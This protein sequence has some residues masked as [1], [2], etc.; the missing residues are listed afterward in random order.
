M[1]SQRASGRKLNRMKKFLFILLAVVAL[2]ENSFAQTPYGGTT[3]R[4]HNVSSGTIWLNTVYDWP[5]TTCGTPSRHLNLIEDQNVAPGAT[6]TFTMYGVSST[7]NYVTYGSCLITGIYIA[8]QQGAVSQPSQMVA[9]ITVSG[10]GESCDIY[11]TTATTS[12]N[13][14]PTSFTNFTYCAKNQTDYPE[15]ATIRFNGAIVKTD[16]V[17]AGQQTCYTT[18]SIQVLPTPDAFIVSIT[19]NPMI[20][21]NGDDNFNQDTNTGTLYFG[22]GGNGLQPVSGTFSGSGSS[23]GGSGG[24]TNTLSNTNTPV[25]ASTNLVT[26]PTPTGTASESTA[27]ASANQAHK[28]SMDNLTGLKILSGNLLTNNLI[29]YGAITNLPHGSTTL[30]NIGGG[31]NVNVQNWP[32]GWSN[33]LAQMASNS[34]YLANLTNLTGGNTNLSYSNVEGRMTAMI[35]STATNG[36]AAAAAAAAAD[37]DYGVDGMITGVGSPSLPSSSPSAPSMT[38]SFCGRTIDLDPVHQFP[39]VAAASLAGF[40]IVF[41]LAFLTEIGRM[42]WN[43]IKIRASTQTGGVPDLEV[44]A[45]FEALTFGGQVGGNFIGVVVALVVPAIFVGLFSLCMAYLFA[46]VGFT[47]SDALQFTDFTNSLGGMGYYLL[48]SFIPVNLLFSLAATRLTLTF[49]LG[50]L[51]ALATSAA[52]W[53]FGR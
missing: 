23:S 42:F 49:T 26:F 12:S 41:L 14:A 35:P 28:D 31:S 50:K 25:S 51:V 43:L 16:M 52:R 27:E 38:M 1:D 9:P 6:V 21:N 5:I 53:L 39:S 30:T 32:A 13:A 10:M 22:Q 44:N 36:T 19:L 24:A 4:F 47:V 8:F 46:H 20:G 11:M 15:I 7:N 18:P 48:A 34:T 3:V 33:N 40:R 29:L 17:L 2:R 45:G 37:G